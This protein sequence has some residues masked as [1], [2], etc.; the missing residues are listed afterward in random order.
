MCSCLTVK[1]N[2]LVSNM[3]EAILALL[4]TLASCDPDN[5]EKIEMVIEECGGLDA[6]EALQHHESQKIYDLAYK[7]VEEFFGDED[8]ENEDI[9]PYDKPLDLTA[10]N[11]FNF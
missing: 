2:E 11:P 10:N 5:L 4:K 7:I 9:E 1:N 8:E 6:L 3:L